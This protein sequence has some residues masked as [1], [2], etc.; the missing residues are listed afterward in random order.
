M[1][2]TIWRLYESWLSPLPFD[3]DLWVSIQIQFSNFDKEM[4]LVSSRGLHDC[5]QLYSVLSLLILILNLKHFPFFLCRHRSVPRAVAR[6]QQGPATSHQPRSSS[7]QDSSSSFQL[8]PRSV[9]SSVWSPLSFGQKQVLLRQ[10]TALLPH[11]P[12]CTGPCINLTEFLNGRSFEWFEHLCWVNIFL[13]FLSILWRFPCLGAQ[14]LN[15]CTINCS[16]SAQLYCL[17][18]A[19]TA[20][21]G[22]IPIS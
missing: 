18:L 19:L 13:S 21:I 9:S 3:C 12:H 4:A 1:I 6:G 2:I 17:A 22:D 14:R 8:T 20:L 15:S 7:V 5:W 16:C 11:W 10:N